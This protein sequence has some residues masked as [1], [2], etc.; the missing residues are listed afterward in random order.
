MT[1]T[2]GSTESKVEKLSFYNHTECECKEKSNHTSSESTTDTS[3]T[4]LSFRS[5]DA[6]YRPPQN[7]RRCKCPK[8]FHWNPGY[9][10]N[11]CTC[12]CEEG[13]QD[14]IQLKKG[15]EHLSMTDRICISNNECTLP[16]CEYGA[17]GVKEGKCPSKKEKIENFRKIRINY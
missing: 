17:Y 8:H 10:Y 14:C 3:L 15:K 11:R 12:D 7:L 13:N 9:D 5:A 16:I 2:L 6:Y 1:K 4:S